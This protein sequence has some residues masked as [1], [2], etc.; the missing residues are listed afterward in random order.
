MLILPLIWF[1]ENF[2]TKYL[3]FLI[4][5]MTIMFKTKDNFVN[6]QRLKG[7]MI[8]YHIVKIIVSYVIHIMQ[9]LFIYFTEF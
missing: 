3:I 8:K 5:L 2:K 7:G 4:Q 1:V 9:I 6:F